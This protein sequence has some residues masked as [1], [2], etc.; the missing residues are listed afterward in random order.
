MA[1][2]T[3]PQLP[4]LLASG[5][6]PNDLLVIVNYDL[7]TGTTKNIKAF[8]LQTYVNSGATS[9][10]ETGSG[11][12]STQRINVSAD[13]SGPYS[14]VSGGLNNTSSGFYSFVGGGENNFV[15]SSHTAIVGGYNNSNAAVA[16]VSFIGG[17]ANNH[18]QCGYSV[19]TGGICNT[20]SGYV[21]FVGGGGFNTSEGCGSFIGG[22]GINTTICNLSTIG[23]GDFNTTFGNKSSILGGNNNKAL[24]NTSTIGGG[25]NNFAGISGQVIKFNIIQPTS[26]PSLEAY[27]YVNTTVNFP[28]DSTTGVGSGVILGVSFGKLGNIDSINLLLVVLDIKLVILLRFLV[29]R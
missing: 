25:K 19:V 24:S 15:S 14:V 1:D 11:N 27:S 29:P 26:F 3:I 5:V 7:P 2:K 16:G 21:S 9:L 18:V 28:Q 22:G 20:S 4:N 8:D 13:A 23:G 12:R 10:Y 6:T 17:G